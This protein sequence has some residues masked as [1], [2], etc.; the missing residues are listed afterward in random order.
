MKKVAV[1]FLGILVFCGLYLAL[2]RSHLGLGIL[3]L[4]VM[5]AVFVLLHLSSE[6]SELRERVKVLEEKLA[7]GEEPMPAVETEAD[8]LENLY[9]KYPDKKLRKILE[10]KEYR[11][12]AKNLAQQI[13][14]ERAEMSDGE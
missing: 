5:L 14:K 13:L 8:K 6:I 10:S 1:A 12:D 2:F 3:L 7:D 9:R 11:E 4:P